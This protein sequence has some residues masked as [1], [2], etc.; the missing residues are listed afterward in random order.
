MK[1][2]KIEVVGKQNAMINTLEKMCDKKNV[3]YY[4]NDEV[5]AIVDYIQEEKEVDAK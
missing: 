4:Y 1:I 2:E 3:R 5:M